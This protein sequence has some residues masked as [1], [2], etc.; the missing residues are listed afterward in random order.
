MIRFVIII[1]FSQVLC[2]VVFKNGHVRE[3]YNWHS[4]NH[5]YWP[6]WVREVGV[7]LQIVPILT[8]PIIAFVQIYRY[9]KNGP[10]DFFDVSNLFQLIYIDSNLLLNQSITNVLYNFNEKY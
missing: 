5:D 3:I 8:I 9:M 2:I 10:P 4:N 6:L 7:L 1:V